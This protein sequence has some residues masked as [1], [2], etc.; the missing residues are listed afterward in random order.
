MQKKHCVGYF[1][2][3]LKPFSCYVKVSYATKEIHQRYLVFP[4]KHN[5][6]FRNVLGMIFEN[7]L[8]KRP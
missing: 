4:D 3:E 5:V 8:V 6:C 1:Q 2:N 7:S